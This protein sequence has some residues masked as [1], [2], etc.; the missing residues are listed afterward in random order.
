MYTDI[1]NK[2][3]G[4]SFL[5]SVIIAIMALTVFLV[6]AI[7]HTVYSFDESYTI[8]LTRHSFTDIWVI[9]SFDVHPPLYYFMLK[10]FF[11]I[12]GETQLMAR[13]FSWIA[14]AGIFLLGLFPV[15]RFWGN[16]VSLAFILLLSI[17]PVMQYLAVD[18]R[19]YSWTML[20]I[21][22]ASL[23]AYSIFIKPTIKSYIFLFI[24]TLCAAYTHYYG[25]IGSA[26]IYFLLFVSLLISK[27]Y[28]TSKLIVVVTALFLVG[29]S[30]WIP[31]LISQM[32]AVSTHFWIGG[33]TAKDL[34]LFSYYTFSPKEPAH[35]YLIFSLPTM[36][37]VLSGML[38]SIG[39][40]ILT[41]IKIYKQKE[42]RN[43]ILTAM[44]F[45]LVFII[46]IAFALVYSYIKSPVIIPRY[47]TTVLGP[48]LIAFS[49]VGVQILQRK[50]ERYLIIFTISLLTILGITRFFAEKKYNEGVIKENLEMKKYIAGK[51]LKKTTFISPLTTAGTLGMFTVNYPGNLFFIY[52]KDRLKGWLKPFALIEVN[53]FPKDFDFFYVINNYQP[54][55]TIARNQDEYFRTNIK[56]DYIITDS[57]IQKERSIYKFRTIH[58]NRK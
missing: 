36:A 43:T 58:R 21:T 16:Q 23:S 34:L 10:T 4:K 20:F 56:N 45:A 18:V 32:K 48:L 8:A 3:N 35:P 9:T 17:L 29:F 5:F 33:L 37:V 28:K 27:Q 41:T 12:V 53:R 54:T 55:D 39:L 42:S 25:F 38:I 7:N 47:T 11:L 19:M 13:L 14:I 44:Y 52:D 22:A 15:R 30:F 46:T 6:T 31:A 50:K 57:L 24:T 2:R 40:I 49:I 1:L 26:V 51:D